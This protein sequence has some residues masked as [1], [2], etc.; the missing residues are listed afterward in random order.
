MLAFA[1][2]SKP[3]LLETDVSKLRWGAVLSQKQ[4]DEQYHPVGYTSW[5]LTIHE[6][7]YHST[8]QEFL[9]LKWVI[10]E[11]FQED[12]FWKLFVVKTNNNPLTYIMTTPNLDAT[13]HHW[14]EALA[15]I[16][17]SIEYQKGWDSA[18]ADA[19]SQVTSKLDTDTMMSIL[20]IV[21]V[22]K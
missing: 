19:L 8:K 18:A 14:V 4:T 2:F 5:S 10:V 3:F 22:G 20:D 16:T 11:Q 13:W 21:T 6:C 1:D 12:L 9:A 7:N 17:F 15:R